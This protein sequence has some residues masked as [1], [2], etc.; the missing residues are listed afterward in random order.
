[1][2][3]TRNLFYYVMAFLLLS[4]SACHD[5]D[6]WGI[7]GE[8]PVVSENR[9]LNDFHQID[10]GIDGE[11]ILKQGPEQKIEIEAQENILDVLETRV[12]RDKLEIDFGNKQVRRYKDVKI[13]ITLPMITYL[14]VSGS[15]KITGDTDF[16][17]ADLSLRISGSGSIDFGALGANKI[18]SEISGS[19][20][21]YLNGDCVKH[22]SDISGSGKISAYDL[23]SLET[24]IRIS[25]SGN[26]E[27]AV[28]DRLKAN[29]SGSG[30]VRYKGNPTV[31][32]SISGS[33]KVER[34]N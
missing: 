30:R 20:N 33:G 31:D 21:L 32:V 5:D 19:G 7:R 14:K 17:I 34:A 11:V 3:T 8:G 22:D 16:D 15:G 29:V 12:R 23:A 4:L 18:D 24:S 28:A 27:V 1:M 9:N 10:F 2:K 25:G 13:Y 6:M 26:A